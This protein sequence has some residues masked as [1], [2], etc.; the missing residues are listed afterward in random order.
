MRTKH[1]SSTPLPDQPN[2][3]S[4][5]M[6]AQRLATL[7]AQA[8]IAFIASMA[9]GGSG[10]YFAA[11]LGEWWPAIMGGLVWLV[12]FVYGTALWMYTSRVSR[13]LWKV[14]Q[15]TGLDLDQDGTIGRPTKRTTRYIDISGE[16]V[17]FADEI[18]T[19]DTGDDEIIDLVPGFDLPPTV[20]AGFVEQAAKHGL[21]RRALVTAPRL[22]AGDLPISKGLWERITDEMERRGWIVSGGNG[23]GYSWAYQPASIIAALSNLK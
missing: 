23:N 16:L 9:A 22:M 3:G 8:V 6:N 19:N 21:S 11:E 18:A 12:A 10:A 2:Y 5:Y 4:F 7:R 13:E 20:I 1:A 15:I 14:E 17:P